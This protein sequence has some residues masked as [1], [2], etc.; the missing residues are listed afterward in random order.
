MCT[1]KCA[2]TP[3]SCFNYLRSSSIG[4][5]TWTMNSMNL[6]PQ[7]C[8]CGGSTIA[9]CLTW[10]STMTFTG[11][12]T[13]YTVTVTAAG[14]FTITGLADN[15]VVIANQPITARMYCLDR[16]GDRVWTTCTYF[17]RLSRSGCVRSIAG[18]GKS[19]T[20]PS[21]NTCGPN[22]GGCVSTTPT[23]ASCGD[24]TRTAGG[25]F[26]AA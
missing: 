7:S 18:F 24:N 9:G 8:P 5:D 4:C 1:A 17:L 22:D 19:C 16:D 10:P 25:A 26:A 20:Y 14:G 11:G 12:G 2:G 3:V 6:L 23:V 13:T 21:S 15:T